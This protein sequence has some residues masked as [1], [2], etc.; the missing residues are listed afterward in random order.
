MTSAWFTVTTS[1]TQIDKLGERLTTGEIGE[2]DLQM[3]DEYRRAF[4]EAYEVVVGSIRQE[5]QLEP[6]GRPAKST[7]SIIEKLGRESI[8][9]TQMQDIAGCRVVVRDTL[10]QNQ[11]TAQLVKLFPGA[12]V[13][14][15]RAKPRI[16]GRSCDC[17]SSRKT[18]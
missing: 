17:V 3:L 9:L 4:R 15:R 5:T 8:R 7:P 11:T 6:T 14:D 10:E 16:P 2:T 18:C 1:K 12:V 13:V